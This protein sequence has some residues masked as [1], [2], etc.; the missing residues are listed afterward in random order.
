[1]GFNVCDEIAPTLAVSVTPNILWP[2]NHKM[3]T[4]HATVTAADNFDPNPTITLLSVTSSDPDGIPSDIQIVDDFTIRLRAENSGHHKNRVYT[5]TYQVQDAC[6]NVTTQ[7]A[8]VKVPKDWKWPNPHH[9]PIN[10]HFPR[11]W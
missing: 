8:T 5:L 6:G 11:G 7:S 10:H 2:P 9:F 4:V 1:M 3:V